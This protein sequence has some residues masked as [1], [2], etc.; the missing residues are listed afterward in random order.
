MKKGMILLFIIAELLIIQI[1]GFKIYL[2][3]KD[4]LGKMIINPI[5]KKY[6][7]SSS[8][9]YLKY[10]YEPQPNTSPKIIDWAPYEVSYTI[11]SDTLNE[12]FDY[13]K[14]KAEDVYRIITLGD[15]FTFGLFVDTKD[16]WPETLEDLLNTQLRCRNIRKLEVINLGV[17]GYDIQYSMERFKLRGEKYNPDLILW[18]LKEDD[19][20]QINETM[21]EKERYYGEQMRKSGEFDR[22]VK[23]GNFYPAW[24]KAMS[25]TYEELGKEQ[26]LALQM[27]FLKELNNYYDNPLVIV[28]S[29]R[30]D[31]DHRDLLRKYINSRSNSYLYEKMTNIYKDEY[32]LSEGHP[33]REGHV[34]IA[35]DLFGYLTKNKII[36]CN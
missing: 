21:L 32:L 18:L 11:N 1:L 14:D 26:V 25:E 30:M 3:K 27:Q 13:S 17:Y 6:I 15:S 16:N 28:I 9:S 8:A 22:E 20:I 19:M 24:R 2:S 5:E 36:P 7:A 34:L 4:I 12:R 23:N 10:F 29:P 31:K 35:Q 33:N